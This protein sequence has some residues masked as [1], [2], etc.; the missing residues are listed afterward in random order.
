MW[1]VRVSN[2]GPLAHESDTLPTA[3]HGQ[4]SLLLKK[5]KFCTLNNF[6]YDDSN[7]IVII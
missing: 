1:P 7:S 5:L 3:L 2:K 6:S 4:A